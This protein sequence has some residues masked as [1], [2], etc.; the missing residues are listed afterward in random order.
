MIDLILTF[1]NQIDILINE[2]YFLTFIIYFIFCLLF[3]LLSL[4]GGVFVNLASGFFFGFYIGFIINIF[5]VVIG[6]TIF[7]LLIKKYLSKYYIKYLD[8]YLVKLNKIL[9]KSTIEYLILIRF[10]FGVPLFI[11]NAFL[12]TLEITTIKFIVSTAIGFTPYFLLFS[13]LGDKF[14]NLIEIKKFSLSN[15]LSLEFILFMLVLIF[16]IIIRIVLK[17]FQ[18]KIK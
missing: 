17:N 18:K 14:S 15:I 13:Y 3:F 4:P 8:K 6:S 9:K 7:Y 5:S 1:L 12:A 10:A 2:N 11:Q 16:L